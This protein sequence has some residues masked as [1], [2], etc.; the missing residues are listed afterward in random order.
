[1]KQLLK[2]RLVQ[3]KDI[4]YPCFCIKVKYKCEGFVN[5]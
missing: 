4:W 1:M 5:V 2:P 3:L